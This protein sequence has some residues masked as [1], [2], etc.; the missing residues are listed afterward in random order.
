[1]SGGSMGY[2]YMKVEDYKDY[3][4]DPEL[5]EL[6]N[7][8]TKVLHDM[9]WWVSA[10]IGE[11]EYRKTVQK[12]KEKW[13]GTPREERLKTYIDKELFAVRSKLYRLIGEKEE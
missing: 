1:M 9:E 11:Q 10:D 7:D 4:E 8:L 13:F 6:L 3:A 2:L 12:F 5:T